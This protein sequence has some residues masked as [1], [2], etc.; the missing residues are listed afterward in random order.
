MNR[1]LLLR[2]THLGILI[3]LLVVPSVAS[4]TIPYGPLS[5]GIPGSLGPGLASPS[6][7]PGKEYSHD[8]DFTTTGGGG[9]ADPQQV[10][11][12]DGSGGTADGL[13]FTGTRPLY[14]P[15]D[16][17]DALANHGDHLFSELIGPADRAHLVFSHDDLI[18]VYPGAG[19]F[20]PFVVP[21]AGPVALS[22][23]S[24]IGG[25]G[26]LSYELASAFA[27][28]STHGVWAPQP[29]INGMPLPRD[30]DA[31]ELWGPE[32]ALSADSNKYSLEVD[33]FSG[34]S[35][36]DLTTGSTYIPH[37]TIVSAVGAL[38]GPVSGV[39]PYP[40]FFDGDAA[41]N[42]DAL[43]VRDIIGSDSTFDRDPAGGPGDQIIFSIR[44]IV[45]PM[46]P[47]GYYATGSELFVLDATTG[48][49]GT[50]YL[51]HGGHLWD[52]AYALLSLA[53][54]PAL[55]N[56][57]RAVIDINAIEAVPATVIPE[58]SSVVLLAMVGVGAATFARRRGAVRLQ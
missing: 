8:V 36:W 13:D 19:G 44:Q 38:L 46:D 53:I 20:V 54:P 56:G 51:F 28:P 9:I 45:D 17:V 47:D 49:L 39:L 31:V 55:I 21:S 23:G 57:G 24:V 50:T 35:V 27:P 30:V 26:E 41:V 4:A 52:H 32:P 10:I 6:A 22:G 18:S 33:G 14:T 7:V 29:A 48:T 2:G 25:A 11:A 42:L 40:D 58:P 1:H 15:E 34:T 3:S 5:G 43:M 12:W 37:G 16:Q